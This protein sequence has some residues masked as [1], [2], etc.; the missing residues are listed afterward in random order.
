[1][2]LQPLSEFCN[3]HVTLTAGELQDPE[4]VAVSK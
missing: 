3:L 2:L 1:M 4:K